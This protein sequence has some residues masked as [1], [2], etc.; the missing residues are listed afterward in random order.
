MCWMREKWEG[1]DLN[2]QTTGSEDLCDGTACG[3]LPVSSGEYLP[4]VWSEEGQTKNRRQGSSMC[5]GNKGYLIWPKLTKKWLWHKPEKMLM[6]VTGGMG[7]STQCI[8]PFC[9]RGCLATDRSVRVLMLTTV[10]HRKHLQ[11][12]R[13]C[14]KWTQVHR[15]KETSR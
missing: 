10:H 11:W 9:V 8:A 12:A 3:L 2:G 14:C 1:K 5:K 6:L 13:K 15:G 7:H 4:T